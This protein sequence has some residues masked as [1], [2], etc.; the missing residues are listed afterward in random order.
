[1]D[2]VIVLK[3]AHDMYD[4]VHL[5]DVRKKFIAEALSLGGAFDESGN[6]DKFEDGR[7][8]FNRMIQ[9]GKT[10]EP[11]VRNGY[12]ADIRLNG[13]EGLLGAFRTGVCNC[14]KQC[15]LADVRQAY[16]T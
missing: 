2:N 6:V 12:D 14:V 15:A 9:L 11:L 13:A 16:H 10:V 5:A 3:T 1:M 4:S 7:R 8:E